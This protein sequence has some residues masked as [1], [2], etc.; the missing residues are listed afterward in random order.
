MYPI[1]TNKKL[2]DAISL[3]EE[4]IK[5]NTKVPTQIEKFN[6]RYNNI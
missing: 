3:E 2:Q 6:R 4:K 5:R 1:F